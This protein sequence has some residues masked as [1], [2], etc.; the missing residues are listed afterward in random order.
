MRL[1]HLIIT[2]LALTLCMGLMLLHFSNAVIDAEL[3][4]R[5]HVD[6]KLTVSSD[7]PSIQHLKISGNLT[8]TN[9]TSPTENGVRNF[10]FSS[11]QPDQYSIELVFHYTEGY[12]IFIQ[13]LESTTGRV[14][15]Y[16]SYFISQGNFTI[17]LQLNV[18]RQTSASVARVETGSLLK[19]LFSWATEFGNS[20]PTWVKILYGILGIQFLL[21]GKGWMKYEDY[22]RKSESS[23]PA[24]DSGNKLYL[25]INILCK[26]QLT[27]FAITAILM[28]GQVFL[29]YL[30]RYMFLIAL[31]LVSLWDLYVL[32]FMAGMT[33]IVYV[34]R[35]VL[36][37]YFDL[38]PI[39]EG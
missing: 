12:S 5:L 21:V 13:V 36:E 15:N 20:F 10:N 7:K 22:R 3:K 39:D 24:F 27:V 17:V 16:P 18:E 37:R 2:S 33:A 26:F 30:L 14:V 35:A 19:G 28:V 9:Y 6:D 4:L 11:A 32:G 1:A 34:T 25:W 31:N 23:L 8:A 38:K 29:V